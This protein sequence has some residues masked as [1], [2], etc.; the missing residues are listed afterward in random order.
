[1]P[2]SVAEKKKCLHCNKAVLLQAFFNARSEKVLFCCFT[3]EGKFLED[4]SSFFWETF[5]PFAF[6][7]LNTSLPA[8]TM[9]LCTSHM[10]NSQSSVSK[11]T[12]LLFDLRHSSNASIR[13][14]SVTLGVEIE[15]NGNYLVEGDIIED[16]ETHSPCCVITKID[17]ES[18]DQFLQALTLWSA[19][20]PVVT[21]LWGRSL[22]PHTMERSR[23]NT[24]RQTQN[25]L[26]GGWSFSPT[27]T[28]GS[29]IRDGG[30]Q[31]KW[32]FVFPQC[33]N[34]FSTALHTTGTHVLFLL[35]AIPAS[36]RGWALCSDWANAALQSRSPLNGFWSMCFS[37]DW[38]PNGRRIQML[39]EVLILSMAS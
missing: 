22:M 32:R 25:Q 15:K 14:T 39:V 21:A 18:L 34:D 1:M 33:R 38:I 27:L 23:K 37:T 9:T 13:E 36:Q 24:R 3:G 4:R 20:R 6:P 35:P 2:F 30:G 28:P 10:Q 5:S 26:F 8:I 16:T 29:V 17:E 7:F 12:I 31:S 19:A 11:A